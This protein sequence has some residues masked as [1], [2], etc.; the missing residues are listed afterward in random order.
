MSTD[1]QPLLDRNEHFAATG[2]HTGLTPIPRHQVLV[3]TCMD[4][5]VDPAHIL[6]AE[7]GDVLVYRNGGGRVTDDALQEIAFVA[8]VTEHMF[9]DEAPPFEVAVIHHTGCGTGLL[10][11]SDFRAKLGDRLDGDGLAF[12]DA[13][14]AGH[15]VIDP[16]VTLAADV[17]RVRKSTAVPDR[18]T[19]SGHVYDVETGLITTLEAG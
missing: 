10:A 15:A 1:L 7:L 17:A 5:R 9:G 19:V 3:I 13:E 11:D 2:T 16:S 8:T 18:V 4:G 14:A 6:G 12:D